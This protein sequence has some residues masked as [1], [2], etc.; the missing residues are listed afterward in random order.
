MKLFSLMF[1]HLKTIGTQ[2]CQRNL[3]ILSLRALFLFLRTKLKSFSQIFIFNA[4]GVL[5]KLVSLP[6]KAQIQSF[7]MIAFSG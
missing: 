7:L 5:R 4:G 3:F 1:Q 6:A 2:F